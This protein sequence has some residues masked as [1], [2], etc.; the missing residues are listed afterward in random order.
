M[1]NHTTNGNTFELPGGQGKSTKNS[2][3]D[4]WYYELNLDH[5]LANVRRN[6]EYKERRLQ[7]LEQLGSGKQLELQ[8]DDSL[9]QTV[10]ETNL[11][12]ILKSDVNLWENLYCTINDF[13]EAHKEATASNAQSLIHLEGENHSLKNE[14][15]ILREQ[16]QSLTQQLFWWFEQYMQRLEEGWNG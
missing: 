5:E 4:V 8:L 10:L 12:I 6:I 7:A 13:K 15:R 11:I 3:T 2:G 9:V 14:N 1:N 16:N